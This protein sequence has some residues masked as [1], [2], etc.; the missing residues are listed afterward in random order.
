MSYPDI[1][2]AILAYKL[3]NYHCQ[4]CRFGFNVPS[5]QSAISPIFLT[6]VECGATYSTA[7]IVMVVIFATATDAQYVVYCHGIREYT[8]LASV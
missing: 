4:S 8:P 3:W 7:L 5:G 2:T 6:V 1:F